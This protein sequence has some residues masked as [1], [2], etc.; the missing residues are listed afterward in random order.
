MYGKEFH[1]WQQA[2]RLIDEIEAQE[3]E[4]RALVVKHYEQ[5][6]SPRPDPFEDL[7]RQ[8]LHQQL[9]MNRPAMRRPNHIANGL[10]GG[11]SLVEPT[12]TKC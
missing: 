11:S 10:F 4:V 12:L 2:Q 8:M 3:P 1:E 9:Q 5:P 6:H 7:R